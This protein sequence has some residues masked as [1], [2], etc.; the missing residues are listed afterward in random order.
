MNAKR[1]E[2]IIL[3]FQFQ[4]TS[5]AVLD[6][7]CIS[8]VSTLECRSNIKKFPTP[9]RLYIGIYCHPHYLFNLCIISYGLFIPTFMKFGESLSDGLVPEWQDLYVDYKKGKKIIKKVK[10]SK[11]NLDKEPK[12]RTPLLSTL[13]PNYNT[14]EVVSEDEIPSISHSLA[15]S[16]VH[17]RSHPEMLVVPVSE[18]LQRP[19]TSSSNLR[20][21]RPSIFNYSRSKDSKQEY[22]E[23]QDNF[24][25]W[26]NEEMNKVDHFFKEK[27]QEA[28]TRFL[29]LQDQLYQLRDHKA[30]IVKEKS[31][32][33]DATDKIN[34]Y[35]FHTK[36][37][38]DTLNRLEFPSL[39]SMK[40]LEKW[41]KA[42]PQDDFK[43]HTQEDVLDPIA[44]ENGIRNGD[45]F[46]SRSSLESLDSEI[47]ERPVPA[48]SPPTSD[49]EHLQRAKKRDYV[50]KKQKF[51]V[52]L[53]ARKL[54]KDACLEHYRALS[55]A[56]SYRVLNRTAFRKITKKY[57]KV[58]RSDVSAPFMKRLDSE[59]YFQTSDLIDKLISHV[60]E[61]FIAFYDPET[62]DRKHSLE[63]L[64]S[65]AYA[66]HSN[67][68][69]Q[70]TFYKSSF[71]SGLF[72]G[73]AIPLFG[74]GIYSGISKA[75]S[76]EL[77]E[78][79]LLLQIWAG[80]FL[81][82]LVLLLFGLNLMVFERFKINYKF[83][84][85]FD[86]STALNYKQFMVLPT[87]SVSFLSILIW[88]SF[89]NFWPTQFPGR[90]WPWI[91]LGVILV[92]F[93]WPGHQF[94]VHSRRWLQVA[95][96]RLL[97]SGFYPVE[98]RDFF[99]G[100]I[101]CSL[102]YTMG[103]LSFF[104]CLYAH[105]WNGLVG[106]G[107]MS[108]DV[109]GSS[110][111]QLMGFFSALPS[112]FRLLQC[113]RRYMDTG[114]WFPHL[115][116]MMKYGISTV[117]YVMLSVYRI[118]K[119]NQHRAVFILFASVNSIYSA[120]WD[121]IMDWSLFQLG[122]E[123]TLLRDHLFFKNP[124]YYYLA[125]VTDVILR[126]Q[127]VFYAFFSNQ[128][129]QLAITSFGIAIAEILRRFIWIFFRMENEH[130]TN[131]ILF[132]A[133]K[134]SPLPYPVTSRVERAIKKLVGIRCNTSTLD[135]TP[136]NEEADVGLTRSPT[137]ISSSTSVLA[138][139]STLT[140]ISDTLNK[141]HIKDFQRRKTVIAM[142]E[143]SDEED[144]D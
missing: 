38:F 104:F 113:I 138:R 131:V 111:S 39:P 129:Q 24:L 100:D 60:E 89:N 2:S 15:S 117:Y 142:D 33:T 22:Q 116:N 123:H 84:F 13:Q 1:V 16:S 108:N 18:I 127:W 66:L 101:L 86:L 59:L 110:K 54:L 82:N 47:S 109:C 137:G 128:I 133:S 96:W 140:N 132:R 87:F 35:A 64:K 21:R 48:P 118:N 79:K 103:N 95:L 61:L 23:S 121:I 28:Y 85:E 27:E 141:A 58:T 40:F 71:S 75:I 63:K 74:L 107:D 114:D 72:L 32:H 50:T 80:F 36:N 52:H 73:F 106:G 130:C 62:T 12:D 119:T 65:F 3:K 30:S 53:Y 77:P 5:R 115:A 88:F 43:M 143:D 34:D 105:K 6:T 76:K 19:P 81:L 44:I 4:T 112:V 17:L 139:R 14:A 46:Y 122:T 98:F 83:I 51:G 134:D 56:K 124:I 69:K 9:Y 125:I 8:H 136:T 144:Q 99:L 31:L 7:T 97:L 41:R 70:K 10:Q 20:I 29:L 91:Y 92:I 93:F 102:T 49:P 55:L 68:M 120:A 11:Y 90:D 94:Y 42:T 126:F 78:G 135:L 45:S 57:D 67:D 37:V 26:L 25:E